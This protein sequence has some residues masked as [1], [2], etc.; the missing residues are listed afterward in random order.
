MI[1]DTNARF[2]TSAGGTLTRN[3]SSGWHCFLPLILL[4]AGALTAQTTNVM[5]WHNNN[6]RDGLNSSETTLTQAI[7]AKKTFGKICS[8]GPGVIDGQIFAEPLVVADGIKGYSQVV[9]VATMNDTVYF[10][11]GGSTDCAVIKTISLLQPNE[12]AVPCTDIGQKDC[13]TFNATVGILG[14]PVIDYVTNTMYLVTWTESTAGTCPTT[15]AA[16]CFV[17]RLHALDI[18]TGLERYNGPVAI[19]SVTMGKSKFTSFNHL[20]RPGLLYLPSAGN[21]DDTV[22]VAFSSMDGSGTIG[23][24]LPSG[25]VFS[26]DAQNLAAAPGAWCATPNGEGGGVWLSG[27]GLAAGIDQAGGNQYIYTATGDGTFDVEVGGSNYGDTL[28]K[29]TTSLTVADYFTPYKQYCDDLDDGDLGS[30]GVMLIPNGVASSTMDFVLANGKDGNIYVADRANLGGYAGPAGKICPKPA[31]PNLNL[32]TI[33]ASTTKFYSTPAF[34]AANLYSVPN[35]APLQKYAVGAACGTGPICKTPVASSAAKF[36]YGSVPVVS[37]NAD[38][39]GTA[40]VWLIHGNGWPS[41]NP[42]LSPTTAVVAAYD[43]EHVTEPNIIP[44]LWSSA[45]CPKRDGAGDAIKFAVPTVA[46]GR[47]FVGS[48]DPADAT[49]TRGRLD[50]YGPTSA[51]CD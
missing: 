51:P 33:P 10:I 43:A 32:E 28:V 20:Q 18:S 34:W 49:S 15:K 11:D 50:V 24:S 42:A 5:T 17:H 48:T 44:L 2:M 36:T 13:G 41:G 3:F 8:T 25:W 6:L 9:Y 30:G 12:K 46:N 22:Y 27:A 21:K 19:P 29:L 23:K 35:A 7:V 1:T 37:S 39:T 31:G 38:K 40:I 47:V 16:G 26:F 14:T 45:Q 4:G